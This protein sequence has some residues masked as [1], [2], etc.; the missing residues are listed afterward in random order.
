MYSSFGHSRTAAGGSRAKVVAVAFGERRILQQVGDKCR[1]IR[2]IREVSKQTVSVRAL[3]HVAPCREAFDPRRKGLLG[4]PRIDYAG[5]IYHVMC[6]GDR[7]E[8]ISVIPR[9]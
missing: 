3:M 7:R 1:E 9:K 8:I 6:R 4:S 5:A 2:F